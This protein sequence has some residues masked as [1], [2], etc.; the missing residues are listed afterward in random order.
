MEKVLKL[1]IL[2]IENPLHTLIRI[3]ISCLYKLLY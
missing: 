1:E 2:I 3:S